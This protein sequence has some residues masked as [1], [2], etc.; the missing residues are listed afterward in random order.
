VRYA[1]SGLT[2][3][4]DRF[5]LRR[6]DEVVHVEPQVFDVL[7][8]LVAHRDSVVTKA[9]LLDAVW[10]D[11][12]V[13]ESALT[14]RVKAARAAVGDDGTA[15]AVIRTVHGRGYQFVADVAEVTTTAAA[16]PPAPP[17]PALEQDI[18]FCTTPD[19]VRL[20]YA[21]T[22]AG[23]PLVRA[24]VWL[25]HVDYDL[26]SPVWRH[27]L[28]DLSAQHTLVR[29]DERGCG[30]SDHDVEF[31]FDAWVADLEAVVDA[32]GLDRFALLGV[33]Q[34]GGV[35]IAY[36]AR[37]PERVSHLVLVN[38]YLRGRYLRAANET[39]RRDA[40]LQVE[41]AVVGWGRDDVAYRHF[42]ASQFLPGGTPELW[43]AFAELQRRTT[44][45]EN[46]ERFFN[47]YARI[48][49]SDL[50][51]SLAVPT[52]VLHARDDL[53]VPFAQAREVAAAIPGSRLVP[54]DS[55]NHLFLPDEPAWA[56]AC[57]EIEAF[58]RT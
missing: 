47:T 43:D 2:L 28:T 35:S 23:P 45:A 4:T 25:T 15:Q 39:E 31:S 41:M 17:R 32:A 37:H 51:R 20:A 34:G 54:L 7:A 3:D 13:S 44:S 36:S 40:E 14:S 49:V 22:G 12:F 30:L 21:I 6:G 11:R 58:L 8:Y 42:F 50:A 5:A 38:S 10:G 9:E 53:R 48:D 55:A 24:A 19:D 46:A 16:P 52:L 33:S 27:W 1:F 56:V 29:Y 57:R 26:H 18:R